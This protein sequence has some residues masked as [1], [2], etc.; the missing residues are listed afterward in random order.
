[1]HAYNSTGSAVTGFSPHCLMFACRP[2]LPTDFYFPVDQVMGRT[3]RVDEY[4]SKQVTTL[5]STF[6][7]AREVT[8]EEVAHQNRLYDRKTSVVTHEVGDI[9]FV[10]TD[11]SQG[12][13]KIKD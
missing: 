6:K 1:M 13:R 7:A 3:K 12:K 11:A 10:R 5:G 4:M 8:E 2:C 9:I